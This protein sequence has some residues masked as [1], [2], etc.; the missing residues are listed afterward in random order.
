MC[1]PFFWNSVT[2]LS[3]TSTRWVRSLSSCLPPRLNPC[4]RATSASTAKATRNMVAF[5]YSGKWPYKYDQHTQ[6]LTSPQRCQAGTNG[7]R[8][9]HPC[10]KTLAAHWSVWIFPG[11]PD[12]KPDTV[13]ATDRYHKHLIDWFKDFSSYKSN[14]IIREFEKNT[15]TST[16]SNVFEYST[17]PTGHLDALFLLEL[18]KKQ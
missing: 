4:A 12:T 1:L 8:D 9:F 5:Q 11:V 10:G 6:L 15:P 16:H 2:N 18:L 7:W 17:Q 3:S 14:Y 13:A